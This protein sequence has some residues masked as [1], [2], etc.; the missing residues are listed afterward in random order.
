MGQEGQENYR[1]IQITHHPSSII[2]I[3]ASP[4][5]HHKRLVHHE[6]H[7]DHPCSPSSSRHHEQIT[8]AVGTSHDATILPWRNRCARDFF[9]CARDAQPPENWQKW[10]QSFH[11]CHDIRWKAV[12]KF[13]F[14]LWGFQWTGIHPLN[15]L[16]CT[17]IALL[18]VFH[19]FL[20]LALKFTLLMS[21]ML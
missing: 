4:I 1:Y 14:F 13:P 5:I 11:S 10:L 17:A 18:F 15:W 7:I 8:Q 2:G 21:E 16:P 3:L 12:A 9:R 20:F 19:S 6:C